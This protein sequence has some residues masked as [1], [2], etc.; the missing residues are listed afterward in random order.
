ML[1]TLVPGSLLVAVLGLP[2]NAQTTSV[3][4]LLQVW[5]TQMLD[6]NLRQDSP[7]LPYYNLRS[8][9]Q[10]NTFAIRRSEVHWKTTLAPGAFTYVV[11]DPAQPTLLINA[12]V[13]FAG[14]A[15]FEIQ[16]GQ[17]RA[18][19]TREGVIPSK[20]LWLVERSQLARVF[21]DVGERGA[22]VGHSFKLGAAW[23]GKSWLGVFNGSGKSDDANAQ[24]DWVARVEFTDGKST[25]GAYGLMGST[26]LRDAGQLRARTFTGTAPGADAVIQ[27]KDRTTNF[28]VF[29]EYQGGPWLF[30]FEAISGLLGRRFP[31][32]FLQ[33]AGG[34]ATLPARR[35]H[36]DQRF[37]GA[38]LTVGF[39]V[40]P[41][42][43]LVRYDRMD[44]NWGDRW[45]TGSSPYLRATQDGPIDIRPVYREITLGYLY[46]FDSA[47]FQKANLKLN[48]I[49]RG[50]N[51][52]VPKAGQ[53]GA[54][55]G[56]SLV[57]CLQVAF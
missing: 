33:T 12:F 48:Y 31:S 47:R 44:Y 21:G 15:G 36:L 23:A 54:Q 11:I 19:Q 13:H 50:K 27:A 38:V 41:S 32:L 1:R 42:T 2:L 55:G 17:F 9:F 57:A 5:G 3:S 45:Y 24:K 34:G 28:G 7:A 40:G 52:L 20:D 8:E 10:E 51:F 4:G 22:A 26:D 39:R 49:A 25:F 30:S 29:H 37:L 53:V 43:F 16:V 56:D 6:S 35:E 18:F 46:A 14:P